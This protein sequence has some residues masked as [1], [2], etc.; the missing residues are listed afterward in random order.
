MEE[1]TPHGKLAMYPPKRGL[2][3]GWRLG[4]STVLIISFVM[5][6]VSISQQ[7]FELRNERET[8]QEL[9]KLSLT[10]LTVRLE[11]AENLKGI[12]TS[13]TEF[14][15][16]YARKGYPAHEVIL[17]DAAGKQVLST[18][19]L[20]ITD[21][22]DGHFRAEVPI[23]SPLLERGQGT[24]VVLKYIEQY[25]DEVRHNWLLW[26][27]HFVVTIGTIFLFLA[28]AIYVQVTRPVRRL[29]QGVQKMEM[30]YWGPIEIGGGAWEIRWLAW[31]FGN[32]AQE[33]RNS[34]SHLLEAERKARSAIPTR[35]GVTPELDLQQLAVDGSDPIDSPV[36]QEL[37]AVCNKLEAASPDDPQAAEI[38]HGVWQHHALEANRFGFHEL[39]ARLENAALRLLEPNNY[40]G[41]DERINELKVSW[42]EW[43][44]QQGDALYR[45]LDNK[46]IPC[47]KVK[48]RVKHTA[49]VW[50]KMHGKGLDLIE[51]HDLFAFRIVVP[52]E[53]DCYAALGVVHQ[54]YKPEFG[55]FK[56][57]IAGPKGNGYRSLHTCVRTGG[58]PVFEV[59]IR[60]IAMDRQAEQGNAAHW[61]YKKHRRNTEKEPA[62]PNWWDRIRQWPEHWA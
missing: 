56:D 53:A 44:E 51:V 5:G 13:V 11:A 32:M 25:R 55:R 18:K 29:V 42:L 60:S 49:G 10:P 9:L 21:N 36:Y 31:R 35:T 28:T 1:T 14:H 15:A 43:A 20:L 40:S 58:G 6:G 57:Y 8:H 54:A 12:E 19:G 37:M 46:A 23:S 16:A 26:I 52:T 7:F 34:V 2:S 27:I 4:L 41:L 17:F 22:N 39:K 48:F 47:A 3:L 59:Q 30:G 62:K 45:M 24:L 38:A 50:A 61:L 33:V